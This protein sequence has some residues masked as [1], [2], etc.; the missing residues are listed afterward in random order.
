MLS[1]DVLKTI[2]CA[3]PHNCA[4]DKNDSH[5]CAHCELGYEFIVHEPESLKCGHNICNDC[6]AR[7]NKGSFKCKFCQEERE[8]TGVKVDAAEL[9]MNIYL[10]PLV[11]ELKDKYQKAFNLYDGIL[12]L[13]KKIINFKKLI[14]YFI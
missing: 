6:E 1:L 7:A 13:I 3:I 5:K 11:V 10:D 8:P 14:K 9:L 12:S 4:K 2:Q